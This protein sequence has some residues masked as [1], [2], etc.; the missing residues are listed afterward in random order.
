[1]RSRSRR[2]ASNYLSAAIL[3][4]MIMGIFVIIAQ[5]QLRE[6]FVELLHPAGVQTLPG[7]PASYGFEPAVHTSAQLSEN[8]WSSVRD[9][10]SMAAPSLL[11][12]AGNMSTVGNMSA[13]GSGVMSR[14]SHYAPLEQYEAFTV[15]LPNHQTVQPVANQVANHFSSASAPSVGQSWQAIP[16][17]SPTQITAGAWNI[18]SAAQSPRPLSG[19]T[20][21][22]SIDNTYRDTYPPPY[23]T[24]S[25][26]K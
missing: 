26:W 12:A 2:S 23:G 8:S 24:Q 15:P 16:S 6:A 17:T 3:E 10:L 13:V 9:S 22:Q 1:M 18:A 14:T 11:S 5:P 4:I 20:S 19:W 21:P 7:Q 25:Q